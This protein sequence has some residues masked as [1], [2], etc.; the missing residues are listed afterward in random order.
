ML[1]FTQGL[2]RTL[3]L[4][5]DLLSLWILILDK[6]QRGSIQ[7]ADRPESR[8]LDLHRLEGIAI[9]LLC[10]NST[11]IRKLSLDVLRTLRTLHRSLLASKP[12]FTLL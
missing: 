1:V 8:R 4:L 12:S 7:E 10:I 5:L 2:K 6:K 9:S 3:L 11:D